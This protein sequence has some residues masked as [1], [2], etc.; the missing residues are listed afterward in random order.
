MDLPCIQL[1]DLTGEARYLTGDLVVASAVELSV[2]LVAHS[3]AFCLE[4][5]KDNGVALWFD[6]SLRRLAAFAVDLGHQQKLRQGWPSPP[7]L[8]NPS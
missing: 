8:P 4:R 5:N 6:T 1:V 3:P 2:D 7:L